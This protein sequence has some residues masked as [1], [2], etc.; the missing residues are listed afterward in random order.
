LIKLISLK[1]EPIFLRIEEVV[2]S[3]VFV[4][5]EEIKDAQIYNEDVLFEKIPKEE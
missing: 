1:L 2:I 3:D 4:F 5:L